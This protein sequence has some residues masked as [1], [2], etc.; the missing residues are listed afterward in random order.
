MSSRRQQS[1]RGKAHDAGEGE[2]GAGVGRLAIGTIRRLEPSLLIGPHHVT[3]RQESSTQAEC[4]P[5]HRHH[6][7]LPE[8]DEGVHKGPA[9]RGVKQ[10]ISRLTYW[11][12]G[13]RFSGRYY[14]MV[15]AILMLSFFLSS[16]SR[17]MKCRKS[18]P[19]QKTLPTAP[20][21]TSLLSSDAAV[22]MALWISFIT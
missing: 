22:A 7:R 8:L 2:G 16:V 20:S 1:N 13:D 17:L 14:L 6:D 10:S 18:R 3:Q 5:V 21:N 19:Q 15:S 9:K 4:R 12:Y 11:Y